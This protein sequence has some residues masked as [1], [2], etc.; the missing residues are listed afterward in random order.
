MRTIIQSWGSRGD[1]QPFL[2]AAQG[3]QAAGHEVTV[4]TST[5]YEAMAAEVGVG[6]RGVF[7]E[8]ESILR[9]D[10]RALK[11]MREGDVGTFAEGLNEII[12]EHAGTHVRRWYEAVREIGPEL[13][14]CGTLCE[15]F[16]FVAMFHLKI[17]TIVVRLGNVEFDGRASLGLPD[18]PFG[19]N[20]V[21]ARLVLSQFYEG[22]R[23]GLNAAAVD[24]VG[25]DACRWY[26]RETFLVDCERPEITDTL[27]AMPT[28]VADVLFPSKRPGFVN[29]GYLALEKRDAP[30][31][32][33]TERDA[34]ADF[35]AA[36]DRVVYCGW[37]SMT[38]R[39]P[40]YMVVFV[41]HA[42]KLAGLRAVVLR[43]WAGLSRE[44]LAAALDARDPLGLLAFADANVLFV[45]KV[46]HEWLFPLCA[47]V[48]H[49]GG[50]GTTGAALRAGVPQVITPI[51]L[52]QFDTSYA[53]RT[54]RLGTGFDTQFQH[55]AID[56][57]AVALLDAA[58]SPTLRARARAFRDQVRAQDGA[59]NL[60][61]YLD[62]FWNREV[63]SGQYAARVAAR[64]HQ[65]TLQLH[66]QKQ[67]S[68]LAACFLPE[69]DDSAA[70]RELPA[71]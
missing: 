69:E 24:V 60:V 10:E 63:L 51:F 56:K 53:V 36:S 35:V 2:A 5:T 21:V 26:D 30:S 13:I 61:A 20:R 50:A 70:P 37:G 65:R 16:G 25:F 48:V 55:I 39:S 19:L 27:V 38:C 66:Q 17:P 28:P 54:L 59:A 8:M 23:R 62:A 68:S 7:C 12:E 45:D 31:L 49:H 46:A 42:L 64:L 33:G 9:E 3:L 15:F 41:V 43:G 34:V 22:W 57:L 40:E 67:H 29:I 52:D 11:A 6:F 1:I 32:F 71:Q 4:L 47:C 18:L 58:T 44:A 14:V